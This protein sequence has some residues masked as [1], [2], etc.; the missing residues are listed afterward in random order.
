MRVWINILCLFIRI[1][2]RDIFVC[3]LD[4]STGTS[5]SPPFLSTLEQHLWPS[6]CSGTNP[7]MTV[8][9]SFF[10][11]RHLIPQ[12]TKILFK[13]IKNLIFF[14]LLYS[15]Q[16]L[17]WKPLLWSWNIAFGSYP[18]S[19]STLI[20]SPQ[21][22]SIIPYRSQSE[23]FKT[24]QI[25]NYIFSFKISNTFPS[26]WGK[27]KFHSMPYH[28]PQVLS[29]LSLISHYSN[30]TWRSHCSLNAAGS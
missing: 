11:T 10:Y 29:L 12:Q 6:S 1:K 24:R 8:N 19:A 7:S 9:S 25:K 18:G 3:L 30:C 15:K 28:A 27:S 20:L 26:S 4:I 17:L 21:L 5:I 23:T 14:Y 2:F 16:L 13:D 22:C